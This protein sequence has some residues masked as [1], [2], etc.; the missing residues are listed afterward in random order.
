MRSIFLIILLAAVTIRTLGAPVAGVLGWTWLSL[1]TPHK[2]AWGFASSWPLN[3][4]LV[5]VTL[6]SWLFSKESK[7][8]PPLN[9]MT[10]LWFAF[11]VLMTIT[12]FHALNPDMA[13]VRW[14]KAIK[15]MALGLVVA[16]LMTD[17]K[18]LHGLVWVIVVSLGYF[19]VKGGLTTI[20]TAGH[21]H[22]Q[23]PP[24]TSITDNNYL[25]LAMCMTI[26]LMYYLRKHSSNR[27]TQIGLSV[28]IGLSFIGVLG[29]Y[30]R[31]GFVGLLIMA[32][33]LWWRSRRRVL[34]AALA[35]AIIIPAAAFMPQSM[36]D[37]MSSVKDASQQV[38]FLTRLD[39]WKVA[40][41]LAGDHPL[42]GGGF[43]ATEKP[44]VYQEY[45]RGE[46]VFAGNRHL[47]EIQYARHV[48]NLN[49]QQLL[50]MF[51]PEF[52]GGHAVH[53]IYLQVLSDHG[54][55]GLV[56]FVLLLGTLWVRLGKIRKATRKIEDYQWAHDLATMLQISLLTFLTAGAALSMSYYDLPYLFIGMTLA[57][58][59]CVL[60]A[61]TERAKAPQLAPSLA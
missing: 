39:S 46:S 16:M 59:K 49:S 26:P 38:T 14:D 55:L 4:F 60:G 18:R 12:T 54:Y 42:L 45:S 22:V 48:Q 29:T 56:I 9:T 8:L 1:M 20:L 23:G 57:M 25:A 32:L 31:G 11:I 34:F 17:A 13:S 7:R 21:S 36:L 47:V 2:L 19:S 44:S 27:Y 24:S 3:E 43:G 33:F 5:A 28:A 58:E 40:Y 52:T 51:P 35:V 41:H 53:S 6:V 50:D 10:W 15:I 30:S 37:R 61:L